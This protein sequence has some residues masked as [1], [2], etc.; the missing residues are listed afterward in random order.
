MLIDNLTRDDFALSEDGCPQ[1]I[2]YFSRETNLPLTLGLMVDTSGSQQRVID[3]ECGACRRFLDQVV[4]DDKDQ[5]FIMQF[6]SIVQMR[7]LRWRGF[8]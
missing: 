6:G 5:A 8:R 2:R 1:T 4:R 7:P 3:A